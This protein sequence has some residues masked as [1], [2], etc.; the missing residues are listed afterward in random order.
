MD[1]ILGITIAVLAVIGIG[2]GFTSDYSSTESP[3]KQALESEHPN[4]N[5]VPPLTGNPYQDTRI[6]GGKKSKKKKKTRRKGQ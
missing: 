4:S 1:N 3:S 2:I 5:E 6:V